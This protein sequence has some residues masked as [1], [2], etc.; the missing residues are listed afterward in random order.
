MK[1]QFERVALVSLA[2]MMKPVQPSWPLDFSSVTV[3]VVEDEEEPEK[4]EEVTTHWVATEKEPALAGVLV[5]L[6]KLDMNT[7]SDQGI[8]YTLVG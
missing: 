7:G 1:V 4:T 2:T 6:R 3:N 5:R 8:K